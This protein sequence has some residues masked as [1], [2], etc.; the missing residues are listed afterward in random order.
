MT[1][2]KPKNLIKNDWHSRFD[3]LNWGRL[4]SIFTGAVIWMLLDY[5]FDRKG[6]VEAALLA[7]IICMLITESEERTRQSAPQSESWR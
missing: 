4:F 1:E 2:N 7:G 3:D 5:M 6:S